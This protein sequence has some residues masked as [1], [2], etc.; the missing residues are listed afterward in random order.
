MLV[1]N[2]KHGIQSKDYKMRYIHYLFFTKM[3]SLKKRIYI[4]NNY[5]LDL[6]KRLVKKIFNEYRESF[7]G[8]KK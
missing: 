8:T 1:H 6:D 4:V 5:F 2:L 7:S 3:E